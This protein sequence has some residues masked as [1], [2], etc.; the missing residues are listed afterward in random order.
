MEVIVSNSDLEHA[1]AS[2]AGHGALV[3]IARTGGARSLWEAGIDKMLAGETSADEILR[4]LQPDGISPERRDIG[5]EDPLP[6]P[7]FDGLELDAYKSGYDSFDEILSQFS[8]M[9]KV[10]PGVVDVYVIRQSAAG[11]QVLVMQ[12]SA[13]TRCPG[14]WETVHGNLLDEERP[15]DGAVRELKE[16]T[17]LTPDRLYN[18]TVQPFYLH[19]MGAVQLAI[20]FAAFVSESAVTLGNEHQRFEW[21][22]VE[23]A[24]VRFAW[25]REREALAHIL[26]LIPNGDAGAVD[27]VLRVPL[28]P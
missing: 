10:V 5:A 6:A 3:Q 7:V 1:I 21:L 14:A 22:S 16:E 23:D 24:A 26:Q 2:G 12:R 15:E 13:D 11:Q 17:G 28:K 18:V 25:P 20:V 8:V 19:T 4:V 27:D 9:T